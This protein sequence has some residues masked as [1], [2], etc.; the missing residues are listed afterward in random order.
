ML[1]SGFMHVK[2]RYITTNTKKMMLRMETNENFAS[3]FIVLGHD[4]GS[5]NIA[6][7]QKAKKLSSYSHPL[8]SCPSRE[9]LGEVSPIVNVLNAG[10]KLSRTTTTYATRHPNAY[11][12]LDNRT[13]KRPLAPY[14]ARPSSSYVHGEIVVC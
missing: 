4:S 1:P 13:A 14:A 7:T 11:R 5:I 2:Y 3:G 8:P 6:L 12:D 10:P 9:E